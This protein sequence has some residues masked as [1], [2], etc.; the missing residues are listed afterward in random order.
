MARARGR[1]F[2]S[3][4]VNPDTT[5]WS[6]FGN[7]PLCGER[8]AVLDQEPVLRVGAAHQR[9]RA[10]QLFAAQKQAELALL[11]RAPDSAFG[12]RAVAEPCA[13]ILVR[14]IHA[15]IPHDDFAGA[16]LLR[17]NRAFKRG[18]LEGVI[19]GLHRQ[20]FDGGIERRP[21]G[22]GPRLE[23]AIQFEAEVVMQSPG[24]VLLHHKEQRPGAG[25]ETRRRG[26]RGGGKRPLGSVFA[27]PARWRGWQS[28][29]G[30]RACGGAPSRARLRMRGM[31]RHGSLAPEC[32]STR[33][34]S[35][36]QSL[37]FPGPVS[38]SGTMAAGRA[39]VP[40]RKAAPPRPMPHFL[41]RPV[42]ERPCRLSRYTRRAACAF[43]MFS[44]RARFW[45]GV[46][47]SPSATLGRG[48]AFE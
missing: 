5:E 4:T 10:L 11:Q 25:F 29:R 46:G 41:A 20:A 14:R 33:P 44:L 6:R 34:I 36:R 31:R 47:L 13:M 7:V 40:S 15:A 42:T 24:R 17:R 32:C 39:S 45:A 2:R 16:V 21:F 37:S 43:L 9:E 22:N 35:A 8:V 3:A 26:F 38:M 23:H 1:R 28:R 27:K 12:F 30:R 48:L 18:V 19:F